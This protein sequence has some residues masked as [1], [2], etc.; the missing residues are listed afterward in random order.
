MSEED[1]QEIR[2]AIEMMMASTKFP[3]R[4]DGPF[5]SLYRVGTIIRLDIKK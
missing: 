1:Y 5:W 4:I 3:N 2:K